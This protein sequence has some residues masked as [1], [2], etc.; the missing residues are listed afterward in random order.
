MTSSTGTVVFNDAKLQA[1]D[2]VATERLGVGTLDPTSNLHV[3]GNVHVT[4]NVNKLNF[5]DGYTI[6]RG[7]NVTVFGTTDVIQEI[8]GPHARHV[9]PLRKYPEVNM[10]DYR[11]G[12]YTVSA[13]SDQ[14]IDRVAAGYAPLV[15]RSAW[16]AFNGSG[17]DGFWQLYY[18]AA[19]YDGTEPYDAN[20]NSPTITDV[21]NVEHRGHW[22]KLELPHKIKVQKM[23][24]NHGDQPERYDSVILLGSNDDTNWYVIKDTFTLPVTSFTSTEINSNIAY[25][26][27]LLLIKSLGTSDNNVDL[28]QLQY[29]GYE[30]VGAGD[31]SVDVTFKSVYNSPD[32]TNAALYIDGLKGS[33][34]TDHSGAS[35]AVTEN[36]VTWDSAEKAWT[37]TGANS[38]IV[39]GNL[40]S[41]VGDHPHSI[42]AWVKADQL[43]GSGLFHVGTAE[44][45]G[46]AASRVGFVD[47]HISWGGEDHYFSNAEWHNVTYTYNG[48]GSDKK[49]FL[50]GRR[51]ATAKNEDSHGEFPPFAM[52]T[53]SEYGYTV[54]ASS[55]YP[56]VPAYRAFDRNTNPDDPYRWTSADNKYNTNGS[57]SGSESHTDVDGNTEAGEWLKIEMPH[58]LKVSYFEIAPYP[59]NGS[60]SWRNY[61][62]LGSNDNVNWYQVQKV[63]GLSAGNG[64]TAGSVVPTGTYKNY[65][66]KYFVFIWSNKAADTNKHISMGELKIYGHHEN[67]LVRFP[68]SVNVL[69]YPHVAMTGPAQRGYVA[70]A[71]SE[72]SDF[73]YPPYNAFNNV[74]TG[75]DPT[76]TWNTKSGAYHMSSDGEYNGSDNFSTT[77]SGTAYAGE[78]I[79][80]EL[81]RKVVA[82]TLKLGSYGSNSGRSPRAGAF[83]GSNDGST[84]Y[85]LKAY[86]GETSWTQGT[87]KSFVPDTNTT[88]AYEYFR[89]V[90][91]H[92]QVTN[93]GLAALQ[94]FEVHGTEPGDVVARV[95]DGFDGKVRNLRV[96]ST[97]LSDARVQEIFDADKDEFG[98]AK[99]SVSVYR[100]RLGVGT[101]EPKAA[102]TVMDEV[103]ELIQLPPGNMTAHDQYFEKHGVFKARTSPGH[104]T[105]NYPPWEGFNDT[106]GTLWYTGYSDSSASYNGT[107]GAYSGTAQLGSTTKLG[108]YLVLEMPYKV[109]PKRMEYIRQS[110]GSHL[111]TNAYVY[112]RNGSNGIWTEIGSFTDGGPPDDWVPKVVHLNNSEP[113]DQ[114]AFVPTKR[115]AAST[116]AGVSCHLVRYFGTREQGQS[117]LHDGQLT[118]TRNLT[119]P[120][121]GPALDADDTPRRDRLVVEYNTSTN[122]TENGVVKDTSGRGLDGRLDNTYG[123]ATYDPYYDAN[124]K[125]LVFDGSNDYVMADTIGN[126]P[127][128]Y[129]HSISV[130]FRVKAL[131]TGV[132]ICQIGK[133]ADSATKRIQFKIESNGRVSIGI[134]GTNTK[135]EA[136]ITTGRWYHCVY[137]YSG[138]AGGAS[139]TAYT[140]HVNG[141]SYGVVSGVNSGTLNLDSDSLLTLG[142][143]HLTTY[144]FFPGYISNFK[145]YDV[146]LTATEVKRLYDMGRCDEGHHVVNFSKTRVGI[147]LGD[148]EAPQSTLDVR[149]TFQGNSP[150]HF[151]VLHGVHPNPL[152]NQSVT[153]AEPGVVNGTSKIVSISG[154]THNSNDDVI[155]WEYHSESA[156]WEVQTYYDISAQNFLIFSQGTNTAGN[157]WSMY[158]VTT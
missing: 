36:N 83:A 85:L 90:I 29:Y 125:A 121:I 24:T 113:Y 22:I 84:W 60:Q 111:I 52:S 126:A 134:N 38:N 100:G 79:Q 57:Y 109:F 110:S 123:G 116:S 9:V 33:A 77:I 70:S 148:G 8:T 5:T 41:L 17:T 53:Y 106:I 151:Y 94:A 117:T 118:L 58:K 3:V 71:S 49:L 122:P 4:G 14:N 97:A 68:D 27:V 93:D 103:G 114:L 16:A 135:F 51:V 50:D 152:A 40:V 55:E 153:F 95:G 147:G 73:N 132:N 12:G 15:I 127:G 46:D 18:P 138:G 42:S 10:Q 35:V 142:T 130:W 37:L 139:S 156:Q 6:K 99:S 87:L 32:L 128:A 149:G 91:T 2:V 102:L 45:E 98:L 146:A 150:L 154:V 104:N 145:L 92:V 54:S 23:T 133:G 30:E 7:A 34:A 78:W 131:G 101:A 48:E 86:G 72:F 69:K 21:D 119:V 47:S 64:L 144:D 61:V 82:S 39:S 26:Y 107:S 80:I 11:Q 31:D 155:P 44:G 124:E 67:D 112:G 88:T 105:G 96:Y 56:S 13:S 108:E 157:R 28:Y 89:F 66:F 19:P 20:T 75:S 140:L 81:P 1:I 143:D 63:S 62:I 74:F 137:T 76:H 25:K 136:G 120:R 43:N 158:I 129:V 65:A 59:I 115:Y 141:V